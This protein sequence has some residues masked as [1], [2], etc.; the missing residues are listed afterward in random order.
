ME[1]APQS[2][3]PVAEALANAA[4]EVLRRHFR[5]LDQVEDKA[6]ATP[7]TVA[8]REAEAVMRDILA[9]ECPE[10]GILGEEMGAENTDAE[11][12]WVLDPI[13]GTKSFVTGKPLF[14]T[15]IGLTHQGCPVLGIID[16]PILG[17]RWIGATGMLA[18][19][20]Q[21]PAKTRS[22]ASLADAWGYTTS[23]DM[24]ADGDE[25]D[26]FE[27]LRRSVKHM[28]YGADCYAY[29]LVAAGFADLVCE[30]DLQPY[31]YCALVP[32]IESAGGVMSD[33]AGKPLDLG[34]DGRV[35]A[36]GDAGLHAA[37]LKILQ[38]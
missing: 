14:G 23:P 35:L 13:D 1:P 30:A 12:V 37:A 25:R 21:G 15:L 5:N 4:G 17:E 31:D 24:F 28:L 29:G 18:S 19:F 22:C 33:W 34:S 26:G 11:Y 16:Q 38:G 6:D 2:L 3:I 27:R 32:V 36:A 9:G 7:V 20:S 8:D 10:H